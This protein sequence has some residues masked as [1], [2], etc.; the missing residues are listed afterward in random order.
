VTPPFLPGEGGRRVTE[1][2]AVEFF[3]ATARLF[4][5]CSASDEFYY[6]PQV[7]SGQ[8]NWS[9][10]DDFSGHAVAE[11]SGYLSRWGRDVAGEAERATDDD[12]RIDA[13]FLLRTMETLREE[14]IDHPSHRRQPTFHLTIVGVGLAEALQSNDG[15]AWSGR[16]AGLP[17]FLERASRCL[18]GVPDLFREMGLAMIP[19]LKAWV[20]SLHSEGYAVGSVPEAFDRFEEA[21]AARSPGGSFLLPTAHF[22]RV[23]KDHLGCG[24]GAGGVN[25]ILDAEIEEMEEILAE[26][27]SRL[28]PGMTWREAAGAAPRAV[29]PGGDVLELYRREVARLEAHCRSRGLVAG[30]VGETG[31]LD[32]RA[33]PGYLAAVRASDSYN[34]RPGWPPK[35]GTFFVYGRG[36]EPGGRS[37][38]Y[39]MTTAHETWPGHHLLDLSRWSLSRALRRPIEGPLFYEGWACLAEEIMART[40]YFSDPWDRFLQAGR[41]LRRA[42]RGK[43]DLGLQGGRLTLAAAAALLAEAGFDGAETLA[44][45]RKYSLRPGYQACY[46]VG[47]RRFLSLFD[48]FSGSDVGPFVRSVLAQGEIGFG[49]LERILRERGAR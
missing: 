22:D 28:A 19:G 45:A 7:L 44:V 5:V 20:S 17:A 24:E 26:E 21:L 37:L 46:T 11:F 9:S 42:V 32:V 14:L 49:D 47:L 13:S 38:E 23:V 4:P 3:E 33:V 43:V 6:F 30:A 34:A 48:T 27:V 40:G 8:R 36:E 31:L 1:A 25:D 18:E 41:R 2:I 35:G 15:S 16:I 12:D 10:W 39:R 29:A